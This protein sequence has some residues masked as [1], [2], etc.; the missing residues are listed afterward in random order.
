MLDVYN[1]GSYLM[2]TSNTALSTNFSFQRK[3]ALAGVVLFLAKLYAWYTTDSDAIYSDAMESIV[4]IL[5][6]F[7][8]LYSLYLA[9]K[10]KDQD[11][12][13]G[14]GKV[15]FITSGIEGALIVFAGILI[16]LEAS[17]SL[18]HGNTLKRLDWGIAIIA[19]TA[20]LNYILGYLSI[21]KGKQSHS[22]VL[23]SSGRHL[24]TDTLSTAGV[25]LSLILVNLTGYYWLDALTA[26]GF[27]LF[28]IFTG[29]KIVR[30]S[31]SGIMDE[32]DVEMLGEIAQILS[33]ARQTHWVD[34]HNV[35]VQQHGSDIHVD[36]HLTLPYYYTLRHAHEEMEE[37]MQLLE[38][39]TSRAIEFN[40]HMDDCKEF[41]CKICA[42]QECPLRSHPFEKLVEWNLKNITQKDKH[43]LE[44]AS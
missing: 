33:T 17:D 18:L 36:G 30:K 25:V 19:S 41:S 4:N 15:E 24:Q 6:A 11:H 8:G 3:V 10:P 21:R 12:P 35:R 44:T 16:I 32:T 43:T 5:A 27:A 23:E 38:G 34:I 2:Q 7:M 20:V 29:Y 28:I 40:I 39:H 42:L 26:M 37:V 22:L 31:L 13:Y 1:S 14:H 9:S